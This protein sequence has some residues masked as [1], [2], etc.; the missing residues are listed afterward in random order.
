M[1]R[2]I[3]RRQLKAARA[4]ASRM[5]AAGAASTRA[6]PSQLEAGTQHCQAHRGGAS[7][8]EER[9]ASRSSSELQAARSAH[10]VCGPHSHSPTVCRR[11][12][13]QRP[14]TQGYCRDLQVCGREHTGLD[15][16]VE[17]RASSAWRLGSA[18][19]RRHQGALA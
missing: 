17:V 14:T 4:S 3:A 18:T 15:L 7:A 10:S 5:E 9:V 8:A 6:A 19:S 11:R 1:R 12:H 16:T 13:P 2:M